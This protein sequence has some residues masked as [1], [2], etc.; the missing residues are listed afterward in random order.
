MKKIIISLVVIISLF[1]VAITGYKLYD[2]NNNKPKEHYFKYAEIKN[3]KLD[4]DTDVDDIN[5]YKDYIINEN[6]NSIKFN[7]FYEDEGI[8]GLI[9]IDTDKHLYIKN[10]NKNI[11]H[12]VSDAKF[13]TMFVKDYS[14]T[15][16]V[17]VYAIDENNKLYFISVEDK[18]VRNVDIWDYRYNVGFVKFVDVELKHDMY[19]PGNTVFALSDTN[20]IYDINTGLRYDENVV[21]L[22]NSIYVYKDKTMTN[23]YGRNIEDESGNRYKIKYIFRVNEDSKF[24]DKNHIIIITEDNKFLHIDEE[25]MHVYEFDKKVKSITSD[26]KFPYNT[27][28]LNVVFED[29]Y[30]VE[31]KAECNQYYCVNDF[32]F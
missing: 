22:Y 15:G 12:R 16:G 3:D 27:G 20:K 18:D 5:E 29:G 32:A 9:Y 31:L 2:S 8:V 13:K 7:Y 21:A 14:Y 24:V 17:Y 11:V 25:L 28:N 30:K 26:V 10:T 6:R 19:E 23:I 4:D 1:L